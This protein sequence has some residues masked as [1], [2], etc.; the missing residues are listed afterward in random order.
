MEAEL[1]RHGIELV[2]LAGFMRVLTPGFV[3]RWEGRMVNIHPSLL[4]AFPGPR[5]PCAGAGGGR[6]AAWLHRPPGERRGG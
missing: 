4:P 6:Q 5:Y 3:R 2:A 1:A